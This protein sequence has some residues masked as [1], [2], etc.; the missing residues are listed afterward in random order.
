MQ[1]HLKLV[2]LLSLAL[3]ATSG[4]YAD[5]DLIIK[6]CRETSNSRLCLSTL[7]SDH[8]SSSADTTG[9]VLIMIDAVESKFTG[10]LAIVNQMMKKSHPPAMRKALKSCATLFRFVLSNDISEAKSAAPSNPKFGEDAMN[11]AAVSGNECVRAVSDAG[12]GASRYISAL[13]DRSKLLYEISHVTA[14]M[15]R[16]LE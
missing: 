11:N 7:R 1:N 16:S 14:T 15:I 4:V 2:F 3:L 6:V 9:L 13:V 10:S 12:W 8:R 5:A